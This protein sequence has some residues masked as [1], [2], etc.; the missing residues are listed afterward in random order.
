MRSTR[1]LTL[2]LTLLAACTGDPVAPPVQ[3]HPANSV[4][5]P[6]C[7]L[8][9]IDPDPDP[10]PDSLPTPGYWL[11][12]DATS[13][14]NGSQTDTDQDGL[15]DF[16]ERK[17]AQAFAPELYYSSVD[18]VGREPK[19]VARP[20]STTVVRVGYL[21]SYYRDAGSQSTGCSVLPWFDSSCGGH[22]GDSERIFLDIR[23]DA[24]TSHWVL[25]KAYYSQHESMQTYQYGQ[26]TPYF[27]GCSWLLF[28][29]VDGGYPRAYIAE[30]KHANYASR[31]ECETGSF[32]STDICVNV[33]TA[34]RL[35]V[36]GATNLG[37]RAH[38]TP[39]QDCMPSQ[40]PS[41][42][43]YGWGREECYWTPRRFQG[44]IP[45]W[46]GGSN[47]TG[48]TGFLSDFGF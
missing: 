14:T 27:V 40:D 25:S 5:S 23:Y 12:I 38:H 7:Q 35:F 3:G 42:I 4:Y 44:W 17:I 16:C 18:E 19:W 26:C 31:S 20:L 1:A 48:Y 2:A 8:G 30:G 46:V 21:L 9:C 24:S 45:D 28:P 29:D 33:N 32:E 13:C 37:S 6:A 10:G 47:S 15:S 34:A 22:N 11:A 39:L 43:Y 41:Y 36:S